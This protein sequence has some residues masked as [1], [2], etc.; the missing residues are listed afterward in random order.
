MKYLKD[1][2]VKLNK[3]TELK[4]KWQEIMDKI[5]ELERLQIK[6]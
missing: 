2:G 3:Q 5:K 6:E 1:A 4:R